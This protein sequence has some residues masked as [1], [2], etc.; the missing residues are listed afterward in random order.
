MA[1]QLILQMFFFTFGSGVG[2]FYVNGSLVTATG[3]I[4][5][6]FF[7]TSASL[8]LGATS[9]GAA[10]TNAEIDFAYIFDGVELSA[11]EILAYYNGTMWEYDRHCVLAL[12]MLLRDHDADNVRTLDR[13]GNGN[14]AQWGDG[15]TA[16]TFPTFSKGRYAFDGTDDYM[17]VNLGSTPD[18]FTISVYFKWNSNNTSNLLFAFYDS[19]KKY[20]LLTKTAANI[21]VGFNNKY[22]VIFAGD[23]NRFNRNNVLTFIF[24]KGQ[25]YADVYLNGNLY[26]QKTSGTLDATT[27]DDVANNILIGGTTTV[28]QYAEC[29]INSFFFHNTALNPTQILD[30][31]MRM[32]E[33]YSLGRRGI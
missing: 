25:D 30:L 1:K 20:Y 22:T 3:T 33:N 14:N 10:F 31:Q 26:E 8:S 24:K 6:S 29:D 15:S 5:T 7:R 12:P 23:Y 13:S 19:D 11:A 16:S 28:S 18:E 32:E 9:D 27:T 2:K 21:Y 17:K 4:E